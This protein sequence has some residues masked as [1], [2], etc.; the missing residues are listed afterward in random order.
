MKYIS[1]I[2]LSLFVL[3]GCNSPRHAQK[4]I[5]QW[6]PLCPKTDQVT[7][8]DTVFNFDTTYVTETDT[9][10]GYVYQ[11]DTVK[12]IK[13]VYINNGN[14]QNIDQVEQFG[15]ITTH[16]RLH[17]NIL[18]IRSFIS[19]STKITGKIIEKIKIKTTVKEKNTTE[20]KTNRVVENSGFAVL[21]IY[22]FWVSVFILLL[23]IGYK[24]IRWAYGVKK[25]NTELK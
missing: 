21:C 2:L 19:D 13:K 3:T 22:W 4:M 6:C 1:I 12:I 17:N 11:K 5:S 14:I 20:T 24:I 16:V 7:V 8:H 18:D 10:M 15:I 23:F 25:I 9:V